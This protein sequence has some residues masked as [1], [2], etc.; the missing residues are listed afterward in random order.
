MH[1][2]FGRENINKII[3]PC[4]Y[5]VLWTLV[6]L[7]MMRINMNS[8]EVPRQ[9]FLFRA[10]VFLMILV[11]LIRKVRIISGPIVAFVTLMTG[12]IVSYLYRHNGD[13][14]ATYRD[15]LVGKYLTLMLIGVVIID[16][17]RTQKYTRLKDICKVPAI[18]LLI[19]FVPI[20][21]VQFENVYV[22]AAVYLI[23]LL[24][25]IES[26]EWIKQV[27]FL[28]IGGYVSFVLL[29]AK[30]FIQNPDNY[31]DG[32]YIGNFLFP[33]TAGLISS[34]GLICAIYLF[35]VEFRKNKKNYVLIS[36]YAVG[37]IFA[38]SMVLLSMNRA[39]AVGFALLLF[40]FFIFFMGKVNRKKIIIRS[41][42][43]VVAVVV[44]SVSGLWAMKTVS[45]IDTK[46][47]LKRN[48]N[49][50]LLKP[51]CYFI[52]KANY[53]FA[54]DVESSLFE[55]GTILRAIDNFSSSRL[56]LWTQGIK[57]AELF[58]TEEFGVYYPNGEYMPH[59]HSQYICLIRKYGYLGGIPL[60]F[61]HFYFLAI[62]IKGCKKD[63]NR[64]YLSF[65]WMA[66]SV[67]L[68][69]F[70]YIVWG[71]LPYCML[72]VLIYPLLNIVKGEEKNNKCPGEL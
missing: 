28:A 19:S 71:M 33:V 31:V 50:T 64:Y 52:R 6:V 23:L 24:T 40:L 54:P 46:D 44:I 60:I 43:C 30:S 16:M 20:A 53:S 25:P 45:K 11:L 22:L 18:W 7:N 37:A 68:L 3:T 27:H 48:E 47:F 39:S 2:R 49:N 65:M 38:I 69:F 67:G 14:G 32:R 8:S 15:L 57:T 29:F 35:T 5:V 63:L 36:T 72:S 58:P 10:F 26:E 66:Y 61:A 42:V 4:L 1:I 41:V 12:T 55:N 9:V 13:W 51:V 59:V 21:L 17:I 34:F 62:S 70:E 56:T